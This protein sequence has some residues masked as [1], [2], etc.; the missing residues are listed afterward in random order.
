MTL[1]DKSYDFTTGL[2]SFDKDSRDIHDVRFMSDVIGYI[3]DRKINYLFSYHYFRVKF[4]FP[5]VPR[6]G[7]WL[8]RARLSSRVPNVTIGSNSNLTRDMTMSHVRVT[9]KFKFQIYERH[10][11][12]ILLSTRT[13]AKITSTGTG[14]DD[15]SGASLCYSRWYSRLHQPFCAFC[16]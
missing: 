11:V 13:V 7:F 9:Q 3:N 14:H 6:F 5:G 16:M 4:D 2:K 10:F 12:A 8:L 15:F 1:W